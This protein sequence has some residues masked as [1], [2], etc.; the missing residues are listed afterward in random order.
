MSFETV[1]AWIALHPHYAGLAVFLIAMA[2]SLAVVGLLVPGVAMMFAAG[3]LIGAGA[4]AFAPTCGY[5]IAG[6]IAGDGISFWLGWRYRDRLV[7]LWPFTRYPGMIER[8]IDY[9][10]RYGGRSVLFGRFVGPIRAVIPLVAGML[11]MPARRFV[12]INV[13]SAVL[14]GPAYLLPG[15]AFGASLDLASKVTGRLVGLSIA[16]LVILWF[17]IWLSKHLYL[18]FQPRAHQLILATF[19][20]SREHPLLGR[21]TVP[22]IDPE[23]RDYAG[24]SVWA[25]IL[26]LSALLGCYL[27]P[28]DLIPMSLEAWR[29]PWAD[30]ALIVFDELGGISA[31]SVFSAVVLG[32]LLLR[33][34]SIAGAHF[35]GA[36]VFA[37]ALG[38]ACRFVE[39]NPLIDSHVL[40]GGAVYGFVAVLAADS[41]TP[42]WRW[43]IYS[44]AT[45]LVFV[46]AFA[47][48]YADTGEFLAIC[49]TLSIVLIWLIL[50]GVAYR[51]HRH[52]DAPIKGL[53]W[54]AAV[55]LGAVGISAWH[56]H[57]LE[58]FFYRQP[59]LSVDEQQWLEQ[60]WRRLPAYR[61]ETIGRPEQPLS[62]QWAASI[63]SIRSDLVK[64]GWQEPKPLNSI[65]AL[66]LLNPRTGVSNLPV[67]PHFNQTDVDAL[68][69]IKASPGGRWLIVRFW[70]SGQQLKEGAIPIWLGSVAFLDERNL[71]GFLKFSEEAVDGTAALDIF[72]NDLRPLRPFLSR[73]DEDGRLVMLLPP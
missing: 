59:L 62:I 19:D 60:G 37:L 36:L 3:A 50:L 31:V 1:Y 45:L 42:R 9:F 5:A 40:N 71:F 11:A 6:A 70:P 7:S 58:E 64:L 39:D 72:I 20:L 48:V 16:L 23:Q 28:A 34:R 21:L 67:L 47:R 66:H 56:S 49:F 35:L 15:M 29:N 22:L 44:A 26:G 57:S 27:V 53:A 61:V 52:G 14:W 10:R 24:L 18:Y 17:G 55:S 46:I 8:G 38:T 12:Y 2:E 25:A 73:T 4:L 68:R 54:I 63:D 33:K 32:W 65:Q 41:A 13:L 43:S 30:Y 51:R 69:M